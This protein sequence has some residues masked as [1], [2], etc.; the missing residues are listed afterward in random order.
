MGNYS[1]I[2]I[3]IVT[4]SY[5]Q[6]K[7]LEEC[8]L[9]VLEQKDMKVEYIV[10]DPGSNDGSRDI[11]AQ[12]E[13]GLAATVL[14]P[15]KGPADGLN[16]GFARAT[17]QIF[18]YLNADDRLLPGTLRTVV[19]YFEKNP[20]I[21]VLC[22]AVRIIDETGTASMRKRISD[23]FNMADYAAGI[24]TICQ[25]ATFFRRSAFERAGGFNDQNHIS[26]DGEL[27][28][29]MAMAG[30]HFGTIKKL[31]GDFRIYETSITGSGQHLEKAKQALE[32][33]REKM[34]KAGVQL[35]S[36]FGER[37]RRLL[38]KLNL[39]RHLDYLTVR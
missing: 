8:L 32:N 6:R 28:V 26:W 34:R 39:K 4:I 25:Q 29:D 36:P 2:K 5:N 13:A 33:M 30:C 24:S 21:D 31:F 38:Y 9:S 15:D 17:G 19:E 12:Y 27:L 18:G 20:G 22:G 3:S 35:Y 7:Y 1:L 14:E 11:I 37:M 16:K 10:V 23:S